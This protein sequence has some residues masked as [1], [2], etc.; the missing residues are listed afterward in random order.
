MPEPYAVVVGGAA[1][2]VKARSAAPVRMQT[3]NPGTVTQT[4]GGVGRNI[5]E[6]IARLGSPVHLVAAVG[7]DPAGN[8]LAQQ[9]RTAGIG[10]GHLV[11][12]PH[13]TGSYLALLDHDGELVVAVSDFAATDA[14]TTAGLAGSRELIADA[15]VVVVDANLSAEVFA[16]VLR[17]ATDA[18][19]RVVFEPVSVAKAA[20]L[21]HLVQPA[22]PIFATT[23]NTDELA[24]L[25]GRPVGTLD[26]LIAATRLLHDRGVA[27]V[28]V[29][30]GVAGS[31]LSTDG[32]VTL[33]QAG[34]T[35]VVD[36]TG[37]GDAL[38][39][40]FVHGLLTGAD[41]TSAARLGH[42]VAALT[43]ASRHTVRPDLATAVAESL[44]T[45]VT[46]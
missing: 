10:V 26:E 37:A 44:T 6:G 18:G 15:A 9:A 2:D 28:W 21:A 29:S 46:R 42:R 31:L 23:P 43:V 7:D 5:A 17:T 45:G 4:P 41:V 22:V 30:R 16:W 39:A 38:T 14:L 8:A 1:M 40:G 32:E 12:V 36:V 3:S 20:R 35:E 34:P 25:A 27:N 33:L 24:A 13:P 19:V 11:L